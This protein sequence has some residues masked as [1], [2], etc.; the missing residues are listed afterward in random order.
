MDDLQF[1]EEHEQEKERFAGRI[2]SL[3]AELR[4]KKTPNKPS[5][6]ELKEEAKIKTP[7]FRPEDYCSH[8]KRG[9]VIR[10][11]C[12]SCNRKSA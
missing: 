1:D 5:S 10:G 8:C 7:K 9:L 11:I 6:E 4:S 2:G 12:T 3:M